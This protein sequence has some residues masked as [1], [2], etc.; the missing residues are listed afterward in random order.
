MRR[1]FLL[2]QGDSIGSFMDSAEEELGRLADPKAGLSLSLAARGGREVVSLQRLRSLL[3]LS[4]RVSSASA[5]SADKDPARERLTCRLEGQ[6]LISRLEDVHLAAQAATSAP[7]HQGRRRRRREGEL[8]GHDAVV[9]DVAVPWPVS[10]VVS[11]ESLDKY[12]MLF[13]HIFACKHVERKL[14]QAWTAL[15]ACKE[16]SLRRELA[17][18]HTLRGRMHHFVRNLVYYMTVEAIEP[19]WREMLAAVSDCSTVDE[20]AAA[21]S[22]FLDMCL[23]E[24]LLTSFDVLKSL[25]RLIALCSLFADRFVRDIDAHK[26]SEEEV[27]KLAGEETPMAA[28]RRRDGAIAHRARGGVATAM[29]GLHFVPADEEDKRA[30]QAVKRS[31]DQHR[32]RAARVA[33]QSESMRHTMG[34]EGWQDVILRAS[35]MF[36]KQLE[37]FMTR[38]DRI[39]SKEYKSHLIHLV[40]RLDFNGFYS[41][42]MAAVKAAA[43]R[44]VASSTR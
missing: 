36:D 6:R 20:V 30:Q 9:F 18:A 13:R 29:R 26:P 25:E 31:R 15:Q 28:R 39:A 33:A 23:K 21:H 17:M 42:K 32:R 19:R 35:D 38:L 4:L 37:Q 8:R 2:A 22:G 27:A 40:T 7:H 1:Y 11:G 14:S 10:L 41:A 43:A 24:C 3:E 44:T 5:V 16:L 34:Q 12:Q